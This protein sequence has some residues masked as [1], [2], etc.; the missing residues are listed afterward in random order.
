[1]FGRVSSSVSEE[2]TK[3][4]L[5]S[6]SKNEEVQSCNNFRGIKLINHTMKL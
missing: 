1:M 3:S 6:I 4:I 5:I 2:W